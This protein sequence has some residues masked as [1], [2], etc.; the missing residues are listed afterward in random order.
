MR[1]FFK[2][3]LNTAEMVFLG[4]VGVVVIALS[5]L[6]KTV[7]KAPLYDVKIE[8][9]KRT[10]KAFKVLKGERLR[11]DIPI[12]PVNDPALSGLI[13]YKDS[14]IT[15][16]TGDLLAKQMTVNPNWAALVVELLREAG[17]RKGDYVAIH[18]TG[19]FPALNTAILMAV[20]AYGAVPVWVSS[21]G[22]SSWGANVPDFT[23]PDMERTLRERG[24]IK[25]GSLLMSLG[26]NNDVG[27]GLP[28]EGRRMLQDAIRRNG[29]RLLKVLPL[30]RSVDTKYS[31]LKEAAKGRIRAFI[32]VG[33]GVASLGSHEVG[34]LLKPGINW[35][36]TY[37]DL[38]L[39]DY[40]VEGLVAK[41]LKEGVPVIHL[42]HI[43]SLAK[44]YG[45]PL[46]VAAMP[47]V[48]EGRLFFEERYVLWV[49]ALLLV[50][51]L[52]VV[53][54]VVNGYLGKFFG[55]PRKEEETV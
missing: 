40:P 36:R 20:E 38:S 25:G 31:E 19:S 2:H 39:S 23:W 5:A 11:R 15:T 29:Y 12:D 43:R 54:L 6:S 26:G 44:R 18:M 30:Q 41:F 10:L 52:A 28:E 21:A 37:T 49:Q 46:V 33:G 9:A 35:P 14:P 34:E 55:N 50:G 4:V 8:A 7:S 17:V 45:L 1:L 51:Y 48:G 27:A 22:S 47:E 42:L 16:T 53:F 32:N 3:R 24:L 13:G